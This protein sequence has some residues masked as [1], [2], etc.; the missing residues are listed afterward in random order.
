MATLL[1]KT[2]LK[3]RALQITLSV[4]ALLPVGLT[5]CQS[6]PLSPQMAATPG[7]MPASPVAPPYPGSYAGP[8]MGQAMMHPATGQHH[9]AAGQ[10]CP[11]CNVENPLSK[12][13]EVFG[14]SSADVTVS[15][16][17]S[18]PG[19][20]VHPVSY[21]EEDPNCCPPQN[22][23]SP[24][25]T[26]QL[27]APGTLTGGHFIPG[28]ELICDGGD[29][30][31]AVAVDG[32]WAVRGLD[33]EDTIAHFDTLAGE[34][35][36]EASNRVCIY[37]PRFGSVRKTYGIASN[38]NFQQLAGVDNQIAMVE[39]EEVD[40]T[41]TTLQ[42]LQPRG[43]VGSKSP[44]SFRDRT[45]GMELENRVASSAFK[46]RFATFEDL[47][48]IRFGIFEQDEKARLAEGLAA[49]ESWGRIEAPQAVIDNLTVD[50]IGTGVPAAETVLVEK[51]EGKP[52]L[53]IVK[54]AS[55]KEALPGDII[56][57][58]L[59]F[60][61]VGNETIGNVTLL[62]HLSPRLEVID[63]SAECNVKA[64]FF[65][66][67]Q[68]RGTQIFRAEIVEPLPAGQGGIVRFKCRVR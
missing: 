53:R 32:E 22:P 49:A 66:T 13:I 38:A 58:T 47:S 20:N 46:N 10:P 21:V 17:P 63:G 5:G 52:E 14:M 15:Q 56:E 45:R 33:S 37:A 67:E 62:D 68:D 23:T 44:S 36:V 61:N 27:P 34:R 55:A 51:P 4:A 39:I 3:R 43:Q 59:R 7:A 64:D 8:G 50:S 16:R 31:I 35:R 29:E 25:Q 40:I 57:F 42:Q 48:I 30:G 18:T 2:M 26:P 9:H 28:D 19:S 12:P 1:G 11:H 54:V 24:F 65:V 60:D 41:S 6:S